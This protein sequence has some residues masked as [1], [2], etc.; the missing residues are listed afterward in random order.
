MEN[1]RTRQIAIKWF[2]QKS[3]LEKTRLCDN[4]TD[5]IGHAR[6]YESLT[7]REI[8]NIWRSECDKIENETFNNIK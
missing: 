8:E 7:G 1:T 4:N 2:N 5:I 6:R 3:S